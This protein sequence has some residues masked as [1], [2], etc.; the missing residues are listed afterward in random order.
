MYLMTVAASLIKVSTSSALHV[1]HHAIGNEDPFLASVIIFLHL[2]KKG[3]PPPR[4]KVVG[5]LH[6]RCPH[7]AFASGLSQGIYY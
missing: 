5:D 7:D 6:R 1:D 3:F 2:F 4:T